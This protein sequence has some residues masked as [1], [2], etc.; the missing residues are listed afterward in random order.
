[1]SPKQKNTPKD[2]RG[3]AILISFATSAFL[4]VSSAGAAYI[5]GESAREM[6]T[7][8]KGHSSFFAA[9]GALES[10]LFDSSI[11]TYGWHESP[12]PIPTV[13]FNGLNGSQASYEV[14]SRGTTSQITASR[15]SIPQQV[16]PD[17][18]DEENWAPISFRQKKTFAFFA[19]S[20]TR[21][22]KTVPMGYSS[23]ETVEEIRTTVEE[24]IALEENKDEEERNCN[25]IRGLQQ[26]LQ[27]LY[28]EREILNGSG[29]I[30]PTDCD[31]VTDDTTGDEPPN[32]N[33]III[34]SPTASDEREKIESFSIDLMMPTLN[35]QAG[36]E[37]TPL[38]SW[39]IEGIAEYVD[40][41]DGLTKKDPIQMF[42]LQ[43]CGSDDAN[44]SFLSYDDST[45]PQEASGIICTNHFLSGTAN[46][47]PEIP[48]DDTALDPS[49]LTP[50]VYQ[51]DSGLR[52]DNSPYK[53]IRL[54][55]PLGTFQDPISKEWKK[56]SMKDFLMGNIRAEDGS[57]EGVFTLQQPTLG[58]QMLKR[59]N[60]VDP[61]DVTP[62]NISGGMVRINIRFDSSLD[63]N[64]IRRNFP[65]PAES[66]TIK[67]V[68]IND[69]Y[70]QTM[71]AKI[72]PRSL[73]PMFNY[74]IFQ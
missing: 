23:I 38:F 30:A 59:K 63:E 69:G 13:A 27:D 70:K 48:E 65:M 42:S 61:I 15:I 47:D 73:A 5:A 57:I 22:R 46:S 64:T 8:E 49:R 66:I 19:D 41:A 43:E 54:V 55:N 12:S 71:E 1:M 37:E 44:P 25:I 68:G 67:S 2:T 39:S 56:L 51:L 16:T 58:V 62:L 34:R 6:A 10:A 14:D 26:Q 50:N 17:I 21:M 72:T 24:R 33:E 7:I 3:N 4:I 18:E 60:G 45:Y 9:E 40:P 35:F 52:D 36:I 28:D 32:E 74:A 20:S 29:G 11:H 31:G 53:I